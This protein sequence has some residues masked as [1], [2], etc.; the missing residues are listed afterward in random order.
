[1]AS[2]SYLQE[3]SASGC[4]SRGTESA[5]EG[6]SLAVAA[7]VIINVRNQQANIAKCLEAVL[8]QRFP[9]A[10]EVIVIDSGSTD[11]TLDIVRRYP[12]RLFQT[13][14]EQ[15]SWGRNRN[16][17]ARAAQ[18]RYLVYLGADA[19]PANEHWLGNL[20]KGFDGDNVAGVY[21]RQVPS[22]GT[23]PMEKFYLC[24]MY[25]PKRR[26]QA[27]NG[28][29]FTMA[30]TWFSNVCSALRRDLWEAQPFSETVLFGE[31]QEW[32][33]RALRA[34]YK[35]VYEPDAAVIHSHEYALAQAFRR[36]FNSGVSSY[37]SYLPTRKEEPLYFLSRGSRYLL[38]EVG[39]LATHGHLPWVPYALAYEAAKFAG[40][41]LGRYHG[42]LPKRLVERLILEY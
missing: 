40:L 3:V 4:T 23:Y 35:I 29:A 18:G 36:W 8:S 21:G 31:D 5:R 33:H 32:S 22:D 26:T 24:Y 10:F 2:I 11:G 6:P 28:G 9:E 14:P 25:G 17:G 1:M 41:M 20:L 16:V 13:P 37:E 42:R 15:F 19:L 27:W 34:G 12:V 39:F 38:A 30:I 7:S